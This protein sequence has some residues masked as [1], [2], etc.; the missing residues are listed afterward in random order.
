MWVCS[1][2]HLPILSVRQVEFGFCYYRRHNSQSELLCPVLLRSMCLSNSLASISSYFFS[3]CLTIIG[4][5]CVL[6]ENIY[7]RY[8]ILDDPYSSSGY[9]QNKVTNRFHLRIIFHE[10]HFW[11][12]IS[13]HLFRRPLAK[14]MSFPITFAL[15]SKNNR[16]S[17]HIYKYFLIG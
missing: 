6:I 16:L 7:H 17:V 10:G 1:H 12:T 5:Y 3:I 8:S 14:Q 9:S 4:N 2:P 15:L 11:C 13:S